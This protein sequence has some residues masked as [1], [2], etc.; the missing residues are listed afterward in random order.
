MI[1]YNLHC[2]AGHEFDGWFKDSDGF[3]VQAAAGYVACPN[4][5]N[6]EVMRALMTPGIPRKGRE[7][8]PMPAPVPEPLPAA[9]GLPAAG[10][11]MP[12]SVRVALHKLREEVEKNCDYVG[13]DF[14][15]EARRIH[16]GETTARGIYGE[17]TDEEAEALE[18]EG[19]TFARIPWAPRNDS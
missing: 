13:G 15:G 16:N 7:L 1:H 3:D 12:D 14:A 17:S 10:G 19:I 9:T 6:T 11:V 5:G 4:C 2:A 8:V 18:E